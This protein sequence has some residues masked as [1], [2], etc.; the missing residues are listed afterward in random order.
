MHSDKTRRNWTRAEAQA[1]YSL[2][3]PE[4]LYRA[5]TVHRQS[6]DPN[7][8]EGASL[9]S[10]KTG[11]CPEDCAYCSQS[12]HFDTGVKAT[13]LMDLDQVMAA[14]RRA[15]AAGATRFC[16]AAAWRSPKARDLDKVCEMVA[17]VRAL[18]LETC[19]TLGMLTAQQAGQLKQAG[20]D[21]YNHNVDTSPSFYG[22]IIGTRTL[23]DRL[24][25]R[26]HARGAG[27]KLCCGGIVGL[28]ETVEDRLDMLVML[29]NL[30]ESPE[31][32]PL[33]MWNEVEGTPMKT[34]A[35]RPDPISFARLVAL[36]RIMLPR[37]VLRLSAGRQYMSDELQ[38]L[39]FLAGANSIFLGNELL[40]TRNRERESDSALLERLGMST[41]HHT[42]GSA[43]P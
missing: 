18:G 10:I 16:M 17:S 15:Q 35:E 23:Q 7:S 39:C 14:A 36:A 19:A 1:V 24:D 22:A 13:R 37:S 27:L 5:Q 33:N 11:G 38:A 6:F 43:S 3:F 41:Q 8:V 30:A 26:A 12:A 29:A 40:T 2:P 25:T 9:L 34:R 31:S 20:L 42:A 4:L 21:Y 32:V 28:G